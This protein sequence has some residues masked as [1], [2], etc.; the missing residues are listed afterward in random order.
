MNE[1]TDKSL[2]LPKAALPIGARGIELES[3]EALWRFAQCVA[4]SPFA[5]RGMEKA[6]AI[7]PAIQLGLE[8]GLSPMSALQNVAVINGRPGI[9]GD[10]ALALVR[11]SGRCEAYSQRIEGDGDKR[12]ATVVSKRDDSAEPITS[13]FS[14]SDAKRA[15]LW[16][17]QGPWS[18]YPDRM[19]LFR[20]RGFNLRD[21]FGDILKGLRTI[22]EISDYGDIKPVAARVVTASESIT[23]GP[24]GVPEVETLP[25]PQRRRRRTKAEMETARSAEPQSP[26]NGVSQPEN[27][28]E[29]VSAKP[30]SDEKAVSRAMPPLATPLEGL[31]N[32]IAASPFDEAVFTKHLISG[33]ELE[34]SQS[35]DDLS[36]E[37][38]LALTNIFM[39]IAS[40]ILD[41]K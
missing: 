10:A 8:I 32:L 33:M 24:A 18:Q 16:G 9:Y 6:E 14:V 23:F 22:E 41:T 4:A 28:P 19:L 29:T 35:L 7:V 34:P 15:G 26:E 37:R 38:V 11:A 36:D 30:E 31:R 39:L 3:F 21:N 13:T 25:E 2:A 40:E 27:P 17:K 12:E 5:P 20:A 1:Q